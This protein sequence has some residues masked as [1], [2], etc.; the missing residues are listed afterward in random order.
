MGDE[1]ERD[2]MTEQANKALA[3]SPES[4]KEKKSK[5]RDEENNEDES[6]NEE[7]ESRKGLR[8]ERQVERAPNKSS[9]TREAEA[10]NAAAASNLPSLS[11]KIKIL[12]IQNIG[13]VSGFSFMLLMAIHSESITF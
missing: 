6:D 11:F 7:A 2:H 1:I 9:A 12:V 8:S 3:S 10:A 13:I 4:N 5:G